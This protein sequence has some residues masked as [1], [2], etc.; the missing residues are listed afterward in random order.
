MYVLRAQRFAS[1]ESMRDDIN[2][3]ALLCLCVVYP[4]VMN[5]QAFDS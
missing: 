2:R 1:L 5:G 4:R 3:S